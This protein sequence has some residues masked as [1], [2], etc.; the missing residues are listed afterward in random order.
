MVALDDHWLANHAV[1]KQ[2]PVPSSC[3][4][5][6]C[7]TVALAQPSTWIVWKISTLDLNW[8]DHR[9]LQGVDCNNVLPRL[10]RFPSARP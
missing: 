2:Q 9:P 10:P 1:F 7:L 4:F 8:S 6:I 3:L 5:Q